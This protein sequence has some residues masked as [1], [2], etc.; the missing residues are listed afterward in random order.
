[1]QT[2]LIINRVTNAI[3]NYKN[4]STTDK[5]TVFYIL[6]Y[7]ILNKLK[8]YKQDEYIYSDDI[9]KKLAISI[10]PREYDIMQTEIN[11]LFLDSE[12]SI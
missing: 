11:L 7:I 2:D 3:N 12:Y 1:M 6:K 5:K 8:E 9:M 10:S 4:D